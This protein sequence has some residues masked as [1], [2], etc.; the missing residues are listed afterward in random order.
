MI[1]LGIAIGFIAFPPT[2]LVVAII[3][4]HFDRFG[5]KPLP[6]LKLWK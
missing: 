6:E 4:A 3:A 1:W 2:L 5:P